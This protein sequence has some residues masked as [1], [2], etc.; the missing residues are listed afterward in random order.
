MEIGSQLVEYGGK[1]ETH[2]SQKS[3]NRWKIRTELSD[4]HDFEE[5]RRF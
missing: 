4:K 5:L 3:Y 2:Q 1:D